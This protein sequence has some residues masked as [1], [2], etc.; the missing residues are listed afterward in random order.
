[1]I[2]KNV[3]IDQEG[4]LLIPAKIRK[5]MDLQPG[6]ELTV[7]LH[8]REGDKQSLIEIAVAAE[9]PRAKKQLIKGVIG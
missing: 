2:K 5:V 1:M 7:S 6:D 3:R 8:D 9:L 4:R